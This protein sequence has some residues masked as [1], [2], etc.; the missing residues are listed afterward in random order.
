MIEINL[1]DKGIKVAFPDGTP[2]ET[3]RNAIMA[4]FYGQKSLRQAPPEPESGFFGRMAQPKPIG[5][6]EIAEAQI[7]LEAM[8][9]GVSPEAYKQELN[10]TRLRR[11]EQFGNNII[12]G[13]FGTAEGLI[14]GIE[15]ISGSETAKEMGDLVKSWQKEL[16]PED[17]TF[18]DEVTMGIGSMATFFIPGMGLT[19]ALSR[20]SVVAPKLAAWAGIG[21]ASA[22]EAMTEAGI[23]YRETIQETKD[24]KSA[25]SAATKTFW[26][27]MV[28]IPITNK[29]G[30]FGESG[31]A[32]RRAVMSSLMEGSQEGAQEIISAIS[33]GKPIDINLATRAAGV[34]AIVGGGVSIVTPR[35]MAE[36]AK[37]PK[38]E[39]RPDLDELEAK[40]QAGKKEEPAAKPEKG[41]AREKKP[42]GF[43]ERLRQKSSEQLEGLI[44]QYENRVADAEKNLKPYIDGTYKDVEGHPVSE[45]V[46][47]DFKKALENQKRELEKVKRAYEDIKA[48][49]KPKEKE[50]LP[51]RQAPLIKRAGPKHPLIIQTRS[52]RTYK[53]SKAVTHADVLDEYGLKAAD[54]I[55]TGFVVNGKPVWSG[56]GT[57]KPGPIEKPIV[58]KKTAAPEKPKGPYSYSGERYKVTELKENTSEK[59]DNS[60]W[61][62]EFDEDMQNALRGAL[63]DL[64]GSEAGARNRVVDADGSENW[65]G[66]PST[67][68]EWLRNKGWTG[69][70]AISAI[71]KAIDQKPL[72]ITQTE[73]VQNA[74]DYYTEL[75]DNGLYKQEL[76]DLKN[77]GIE[78]DSIRQDQ[79]K[80][81]TNLKEEIQ[82]ETHEETAGGWN[83]TPEE[84]E[85][86]LKEKDIPFDDYYPSPEDVVEESKT[87]TKRTIKKP[88]EKPKAKEPSTQISPGISLADDAGYIY[89]DPL[90]Q[91]VKETLDKVQATRMGHWF[92]WLRGRQDAGIQVY[93]EQRHGPQLLSSLRNQEGILSQTREGRAIYEA[94][95]EFKQ[96]TMRQFKVWRAQ[97]EKTVAGL[98]AQEKRAVLHL[99]DTK[100]EIEGPHPVEIAAARVREILGE[101]RQYLIDHGHH[102]GHIEGYLPHIFQGRFWV[103]AK[104]EHSHKVESLGQALK[105]AESWSDQ[106]KTNIAIHQDTFIP[107]DDATMLNRRGYW[108]LVSAIQK[109]AGQDVPIFQ[110]LTSKEISHMLSEKK[111]ARP[112]PKRRFFGNQMQRVVNNPN[113]I[114]NLDSIMDIYFYGASRKVSQDVVMK[115]VQ[116]N[117]EAMPAGDQRL[118]AYIENEALPGAL[119]HPTNTEEAIANVIHKLKLSPGFNAQDVRT[120][121]HKI[122]L[123]QYVMDLGLSATSAVANA[124][125]FWVNAYPIVGE[126]AAVRGYAK[127]LRTFRNP[128]LLK[129]AEEMGITQ[130]V[131]SITG[132]V[133]MDKGTFKEFYGKLLKG[134][135]GFQGFQEA[136]LMPFSTVELINRFSAYWAGKD[137]A[138]NQL[139]KG[140]SAVKMAGKVAPKTSSLMLLAQEIDQRLADTKAV[141]NAVWKKDTA[142]LQEEFARKF[143]FEL[144]DK[145]NF[146]AG[147]ENLPSLLK[148]VPVRLLSPYKSFL[149]NQ[150][151][152]TVETLSPKGVKTNPMKALRFTAVTLA[153]AGVAGNPIIYGMFLAVDTLLKKLF[154]IDT[155]K[156]LRRNRLTRGIFGRLGI[157]ISG[158]VAIIL[159]LR[160]YDVMGRF[161]KIAVEIGKLTAGK[162]EGAGTIRTERKLE[163]LAMPSQ[164]QRVVDAINI[165]ENDAYMTPITKTPVAIDEPIWSAAVKRAI[166]FLPAS[167]SEAF[168][169]EQ[170]IQKKKEKYKSLSSDLTERWATAVKEQDEKTMGRVMEKVLK[171]LNQAIDNVAGARTKD[172]LMTAMTDLFFWK[173]W[174]DQ[175]QK[176]KQAVLRK[177]VPRQIEKK[178]RLP[179]YLRPEAMTP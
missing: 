27:N 106:G 147:R 65:Q 134:E 51:S 60:Q 113:F 129:E 160:L 162:L 9:R 49:E 55:N 141:R 88:G 114:K 71:Q 4:E 15:W 54:V 99:L 34:G 176:F 58:P 64:K 133:L 35:A 171:E 143:G 46:R 110:E 36:T 158:S 167:V 93:L 3:M 78:S 138:K 119:A 53:S 111:I 94:M 146:R 122:N 32:V 67:Y 12:A 154:G 127:G 136:T 33:Q 87:P 92:N 101:V 30:V 66:I 86:L 151:K 43:E 52:Q 104:D 131:S 8:Q 40:Y 18:I 72:R 68:P 178:R 85:A 148:E 115:E 39:P 63:D 168:E 19:G 140:R 17:P 156:W 126:K 24:K 47:D 108:R 152:Y 7:G 31:K 77:E 144:N 139:K 98:D 82:R 172:E 48:G 42:I 14:G 132:E 157:D 128:D 23:S 164:M 109:Q 165:L 59:A 20:A 44:E 69:K 6:A 177:F 130:S 117:M 163:R 103:K 25:E 112:K 135:G 61:K 80:A 150:I 105:I 79:A 159:P 73:I 2:E 81:Q 89:L 161:G 123:V 166:G 169:V 38:E 107:P 13:A 62:I 95:R 149:T 76:E 29:L 125:Q 153:L 16:V 84:F 41:V 10:P 45:A 118:R 91:K 70:N 1:K 37:P 173:A 22:M 179:L 5:P 100:E 90:Y 21:L 97:Y 120:V 50:V 121:F 75:E 74:I 96:A 28:L 26:M 142:R 137:Y 174:I 83:Y 170:E 155:K 116:R 57:I 175:D 102:V 124:S 145:T 56:E 11:L